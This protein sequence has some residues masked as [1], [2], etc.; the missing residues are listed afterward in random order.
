MFSSIFK[1]KPPTV[2]KRPPFLVFIALQNN[3]GIAEECG[4]H[5]DMMAKF[6][7]YCAQVKTEQWLTI[8]DAVLKV[9][10]IRY[11]RYIA[12]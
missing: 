6:F 4:N 5:G 8:D 10:E 11:V 12:Q 9:A 7:K 2:V 1:P 3:E